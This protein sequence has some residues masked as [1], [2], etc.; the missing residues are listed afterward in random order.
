MGGIKI[1]P[2]KKRPGE[3]EVRPAVRGSSEL[4]PDHQDKDDYRAPQ[5]IPFYCAFELSLQHRDSPA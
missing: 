4:Q 5:A 1:N 3:P 2:N